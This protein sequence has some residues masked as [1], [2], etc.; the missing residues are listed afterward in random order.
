MDK[1]EI[2]NTTVYLTHFVMNIYVCLNVFPLYGEDD[3]F[4]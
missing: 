1:Q 3:G 2:N 4:T